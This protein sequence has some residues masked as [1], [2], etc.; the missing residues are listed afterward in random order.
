MIFMTKKRQQAATGIALLC[1][2]ASPLWAQQENNIQPAPSTQAASTAQPVESVITLLMLSPQEI[3][4][5]DRIYDKYAGLRLEQEAKIAIWQDELKQAQSKMPP[6]GRKQ[7]KIVGNIKGAEQRIAV[8]FTKARADA[9]KQLMPAHHDHLMT[10]PPDPNN[11]RDDK[12]RQLLLMP[13]TDL[14]QTSVDA[15]TARKLLDARAY[16]AASPRYRYYSSPFYFG[17]FGYGHYGRGS[18]PFF[19]PHWG[20]VWGGHW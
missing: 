14:W 8:V 6:D 20:T 12:Y 3:G 4:K 5:L 11:V 19:S 7:A 9:L 15:A 2:A 10:V 16:A 18:T 13:P 17:S 1:L